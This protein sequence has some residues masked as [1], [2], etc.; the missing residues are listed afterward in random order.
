LIDFKDKVSCSPGRHRTGIAEKSLKVLAHPLQESS[1]YRHAS[2]HLVSWDAGLNPA[3]C[4]PG[5]LSTNQAAFP[6]LASVRYLIVFNNNNKV[7]I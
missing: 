6:G 3:P 4:I 2:A 5:K 7:S 1:A